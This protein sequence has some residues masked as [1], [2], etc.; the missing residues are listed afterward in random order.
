MSHYTQELITVN[1]AARILNVAPRT[2]ARYRE[3]GR[4]PYIRYSPRKILFRKSDIIQFIEESYRPK[5]DYLE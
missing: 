4:L 3:E 2:V 5:C 1:E